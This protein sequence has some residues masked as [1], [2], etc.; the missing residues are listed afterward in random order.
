MEQKKARIEIVVDDDGLSI[1]KDGVTI[2]LTNQEV[3]SLNRA[4]KQ[5]QLELLARM[6]QQ[7]KRNLH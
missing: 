6:E 3:A 7:K 2:A 5:A 4:V 1:T